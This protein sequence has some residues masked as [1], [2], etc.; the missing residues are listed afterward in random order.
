M[1][2][3]HAFQKQISPPR[4]DNFPFKGSFSFPSSFSL[5][6]PTQKGPDH[7]PAELRHSG[8][9]FENL[10]VRTLSSCLCPV[11][12]RLRGAGENSTVPAC[13]RSDRQTQATANTILTHCG[14]SQQGADVHPFLPTLRLFGDVWSTFRCHNGR[15]ATTS[16][17]WVKSAR[18][19]QSPATH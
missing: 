14:D 6:G 3:A 17:L 7:K 4:R 5:A 19:S 12:L 15:G 2:T 1:I 9:Q 10:I 13:P 16:I 11:L 18:T 8:T